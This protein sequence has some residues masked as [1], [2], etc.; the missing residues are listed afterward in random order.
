MVRE[1]RDLLDMPV[2]ATDTG[3]RLGEVDKL[4]FEPGAH[5]MLGLVVKPTDKEPLLLLPRDKVRSIGKD[6][7]TTVDE[8]SLQVLD[9][10]QHARRLAEGPGHL[11]G[12]RILTEDGDDLGKVDNVLLNDDLSVAS[13]QVS[14]GLL[15]MS[16]REFRVS[17][18]VS[19]GPDAIVISAEARR[20]TADGDALAR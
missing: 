8:A 15:G 2:I 3:R 7:V 13:Y 4:L 9:S 5:A 18:V 17:D 12:L 16:K 11:S 10:D 19:A 20:R 14:T 6:A 1:A